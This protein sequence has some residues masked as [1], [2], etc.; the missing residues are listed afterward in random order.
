MPSPRSIR[1]LLLLIL[2]V[3]SISYAEMMPE[4]SFPALGEIL[5]HL[6]ESS[7]A[8]AAEAMRIEESQA[9]YEAAAS[10]SMPRVSSYARIQGQYETRFNSEADNI[11]SFDVG[12][13]ASI[14][15][16]LP[17]Y[18]WGEIQARKDQALGRKESA[19]AWTERRKADLRQNIRR[20]YIEYQLALQA[21]TI[22][23]EGISYAKNKEE[24]MR[25]MLESGN[26]S[27][28]SVYEAQIYAQE[29]M[30][31]LTDCESRSVYYL[32]L[33]REAS[34]RP[35]LEIPLEAIPMI[36]PLEEEQLAALQQAAANQDSEE[37]L[38]IE[39]ELATESAYNKELGTRNKPKID[40]VLSSNLDYVD[41]YRS[42][43][44]YE[45]VP[46]INSWIGLQANWQ[47]YDGGGIRAE[48]R[49]SM[50]RVR[51]LEARIAEA[52]L[53][54][55]REASSAAREARLNASRIETRA[56][57]LAMLEDS[58]RLMEAQLASGSTPANDLFQRKLDLERTRVD[59]LRA[60]AYYTLYIAELREMATPFSSQ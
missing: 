47:I 5:L 48:Q 31:E 7:P 18:R 19:T 43:G 1:P 53:R 56:A 26:T 25:A 3:C 50:A 36:E 52:R 28:R 10:A 44:D 34:G 13:Y 27:R 35:Q 14:N 20:F 37:T 15:A 54:H 21:A 45:N 38:A 51:R 16:S 33:L 23:S 29:R 2:P 59:L 17:I 57:R 4:D 58:I 49:A 41:E 32:D 30:E 8:I 6:D 39:G 42:G 22:A 55:L 9:S 46:R 24:G 11:N 40:A 60:C 12:P